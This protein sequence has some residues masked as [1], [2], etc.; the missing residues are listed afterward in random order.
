M[1]LD[2]AMIEMMENELQGQSG[3]EKYK[4]KLKAILYKNNGLSNK[5]IAEELGVSTETVRRWIQN[6]NNQGFKALE[7]K[8]RS[9]RPASLTPKQEEKIIS[10]LEKHP[11]T[12]GY[13]GSRWSIKMVQE[14]VL[15]KFNIRLSKSSAHRLLSYNRAESRS[16]VTIGEQRR[17]RKNFEM[18]F[19]ELEHE[20]RAGGACWYVHRLYLGRFPENAGVLRLNYD[21]E[22]FCAVN[23]S[24]I[25][26]LGESLLETTITT[27]SMLHSPNLSGYT[28]FIRRL[29]KK[30]DKEKGPEEK[31]V[32][33]ALKS[34]DAKP[35]KS[36]RVLI[37]MQ[38]LEWE[39]KVAKEIADD[40][41]KQVEF[42]FLPINSL[43]YNIRHFI[44][45]EKLKKHLKKSLKQS[46][47]SAVDV[48]S[49]LLTKVTEAFNEGL[50]HYGKKH[51]TFGKC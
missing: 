5:Q 38:Q 41:E 25:D 31:G 36:S 2:G 34:R 22:L 26:S 12:E 30:G 46:N 33:E 37:L 11:I 32:E 20:R 4:M 13:R 10:L 29:I 14:T 15:K 47:L 49:Q 35:V 48:K 16:T 9:G 39:K 6:F 45:M 8:E 43:E 28:G 23:I 17:I 27:S 3:N 40:Y 7:E 50:R 19:N 44:V 51:K 1:Q 24:N 21:Y 42:L 18:W